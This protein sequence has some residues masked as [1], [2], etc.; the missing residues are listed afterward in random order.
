MP[1]LTPNIE[2]E[3]SASSA[4]PSPEVPTVSKPLEEHTQSGPESI[5]DSP[6]CDTDAG[7]FPPYTRSLLKVSIPVVV[8]LA[9]RKQ[10][11]DR[12]LEMGPG[13]IIQFEKSCDEMLTL[14]AGNC[15]IASGEAIKVGDKFGLRILSIVPP[16]ERFIPVRPVNKR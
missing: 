6:P 4:V 1:E 11:L 3:T 5:A 16:E 12:V 10:K 9:E 7:K 8:T 15:K 14:E 13:Q 2:A